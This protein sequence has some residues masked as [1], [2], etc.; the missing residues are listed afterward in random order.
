M[1]R[2]QPLSSSPFCC[3]RIRDAWVGP[4]RRA[5][6]HLR[7][8]WACFGWTSSLGQLSEDRPQIFG[9]GSYVGDRPFAFGLFGE[10]RVLFE[11][12]PAV[13]A[14]C[15]Y[16]SDNGGH[17]DVTLAE[18]AV[19]SMLH[20]LAVGELTGLHPRRNRRVHVLQVQVRDPLRGLSCQLGGIHPADE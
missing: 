12:V 19:H 10:D 15:P 20:S 5:L 1:W 18:W 16:V 11:G 6:R 7:R 9:T 4:W 17:V 13:I 14:V 3:W 8:W 2:S